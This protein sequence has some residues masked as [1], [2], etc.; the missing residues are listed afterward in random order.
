[1]INGYLERFLESGRLVRILA[2]W[3]PRL[4]GLHLYYPDRK[5]VPAKLRALIDFLRLQE[6]V[7]QDA[8]ILLA[9]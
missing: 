5:R 1:M 9:E 2:D 4:E 8:S 6:Q 3:S 7:T